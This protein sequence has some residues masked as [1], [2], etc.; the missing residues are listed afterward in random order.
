M[1][2]YWS[3]FRDFLTRHYINKP[4]EKAKRKSSQKPK[5]IEE[6][7]IVT[8][9]RLLIELS[10]KAKYIEIYTDQLITKLEDEYDGG[11]H[12]DEETFDAFDTSKEHKEIARK[13][14]LNLVEEPH[15]W[16]AVLHLEDDPILPKKKYKKKVLWVKCNTR[17]VDYPYYSDDPLCESEMSGLWK[18]Y[19]IL[20]LDQALPYLFGLMEEKS[21]EIVHEEPSSKRLDMVE[22]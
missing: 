6:P 17:I 10:K 13:E 8:Q 22:F 18:D 19:E 1:K 16:E 3:Q 2:I 21:E 9:A 5:T 20:T 4:P 12:G 15:R 11:D 14:I 7:E